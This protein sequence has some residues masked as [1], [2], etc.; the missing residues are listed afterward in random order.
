MNKEEKEILQ[1]QLN[2]EKQLVADLKHIF[3]QAQDD[4]VNKIIDLSR[5]K[6]MENLQAI[7]FQK[8]YQEV[9]RTQLDAAIDMLQANEYTTIQ[10]YLNDCYTSGYTAAMY[11]VA[12]SS[13]V[14]IIVPIDTKAVTR[15]IQIDSKLSKTLY[16]SLDMSE[17]KK[18]V[19]M[20]V[21]RGILNGSSWLDIGAKIGKNIKGS[22]F[23]KPLNYGIRI[24]RTE[25]HRIQVASAMDAQAEAKRKG[26][27]VVKQWSATLDSATR[28][29]HQELDGQ[30]RETDED[31]EFSGGKVSAPGM[32]GSP[33]EDCNCRCRLN[34]RARWSLTEEELEKLKGRAAFFGLDKTKEFEGF[35]VKYLK[36][37]D[38]EKDRNEWIDINKKYKSPDEAFLLGSDKDYERYMELNNRFGQ[39]VEKKVEKAKLPDFNYM[40]K[41][42]LISYANK[43]IKASIDFSGASN[44]SVRSVVSTIS[45]LQNEGIDFDGLKI[46]FGRPHK[47]AYAFYDHVT[48]EIY[49]PKNNS[50]V[51][52]M[53]R[54][55]EKCLLKYGVTRNAVSTYEGS[56]LHELG[57]YFDYLHNQDLSRQ[58]SDDFELLKRSYKIS[59]YSSSR[60]G[61]GSP[62]GSESFAENF[63]A[64][65]SG[66]EDKVDK[67][68]ID[69]IKK[70]LEKS[71]ENSKIISGA[72]SG[73]RNPYGNKAKE[74]A[75]RYYGLVRSM[76]TDVS[77]I[78]ASTGISKKDIQS[79][80]DFIFNEKH[81]LGGEEPEYFEPDYMMAES[82]QRL[83]EGKPEQHD[84]TLLNHE[85][86]EKELMSKGMTQEEAHIETSKKYNYSKEAGEF[87]AK[88]E[89]YK[90]E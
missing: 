43:N 46:K 10:E 60:S 22:A 88:I 58:L 45:R 72:V 73:A 81:D 44:E 52:K 37:A 74:H 11:E 53:I 77:K 63:S 20:E 78:S 35:K 13:E 67:G 26:A 54:D 7:I 38:N 51:K 55:D 59:F 41:K 50:F 8:Q 31:F 90:K 89:K 2:R 61:I 6:D 84:L 18:S 56:F 24:A 27:D 70:A 4:V 16:K 66:Y 86:M 30:I 12:K 32:F 36:A 33:A 82:W 65:F 14:P 62:K 87:Y 49:I 28:P 48:N 1:S 75:E 57:H 34:T 76:K 15:A 83:I 71:S 47:D 21:S 68:V 64:Y 9:L 5:R 3:G 19:R 85:I 17:L 42:D 80:K 69:I 40:S 39:Y 23:Q 79:V 29:T 25:G